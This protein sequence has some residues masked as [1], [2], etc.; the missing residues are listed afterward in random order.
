M[1]PDPDFDE[2]VSDAE[3]GSASASAASTTCSWSPAPRPS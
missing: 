3:P 1:S 2:L